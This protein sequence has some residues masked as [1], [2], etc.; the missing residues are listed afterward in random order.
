MMCEQDGK[1]D[2]VVMLVLD[3]ILADIGVGCWYCC[4]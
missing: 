1:T 2:D 3:G 4:C